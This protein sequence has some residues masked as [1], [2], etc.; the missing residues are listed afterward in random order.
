MPRWE[1][2]SMLKELPEAVCKDVDILL[3][4]VGGP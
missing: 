2:V 1:G 4:A 3:Q